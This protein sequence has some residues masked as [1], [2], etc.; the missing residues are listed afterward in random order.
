MWATARCWIM[1]RDISTQTHHHVEEDVTWSSCQK[2]NP[3]IDSVSH[4]DPSSLHL[5]PEMMSSGSL[6]LTTEVCWEQTASHLR[7]SELVTVRKT[8]PPTPHCLWA[9]EQV[10]I[11]MQSKKCQRSVLMMKRRCEEALVLLSV[12]P[13]N[14][15][16]C[17]PGNT[18]SI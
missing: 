10:S 2:S 9:L 1:D 13:L 11:L 17:L 6:P 15:L 5:Y 4:P 12:S 7:E 18:I 8:Y 14:T 3:C 16:W